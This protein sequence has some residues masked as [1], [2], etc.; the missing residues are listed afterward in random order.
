MAADVGGKAQNVIDKIIL[1]ISQLVS[2]LEE[3]ASK[4]GPQAEE[5]RKTVIGKAGKSV[6]EMQKGAAEFGLTIKKR[7]RASC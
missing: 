4:T 7:G 6:H 2:R 1:I 5:L 3:W